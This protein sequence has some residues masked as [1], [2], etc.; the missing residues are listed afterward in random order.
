MTHELWMSF[1]ALTGVW[2]LAVMLP[3]PNFL[4]TAHASAMHS[5]ASG[6][7]TAL[8]VAVGTAV[9]AVASLFGLG[10]LFRTAAGLYAAVKLVGGAYLVWTGLRTMWRGARGGGAGDDAAG[11]AGA[12]PRSAFRHG[13]LVDLANPKAAA[14]F[15]SLF[16]VSIPPASPL[17]FKALAVVVVVV[18][19]WAWYS[20]VAVALSLPPV[21][22]LLVRSR[23]A[24]ALLSGA[25]FVWLGW[26][27][28]TDR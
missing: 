12:P 7:L 10:V 15:A 13:L 27:L 8:G 25:V 4:A 23:R 19:S 22:R 2:V 6:L 18:T 11:A 9:W 3:G 14:F 17:W 20:F 28:A 26:D 24:V 16:A 5:R 1:L 21:A